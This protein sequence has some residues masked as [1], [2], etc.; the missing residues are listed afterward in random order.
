MWSASATLIGVTDKGADP[1]PAEETAAA[2]RHGRRD[3]EE[4]G[5][6]WWFTLGDPVFVFAGLGALLAYKY[7]QRSASMRAANDRP[8]PVQL[9]EAA[10]CL[11]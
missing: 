3:G 5:G 7:L 8:L 9:D 4:I 1:R 2:N 6:S 10:M 11:Q